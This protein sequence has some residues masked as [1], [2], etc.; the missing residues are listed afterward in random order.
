[1]DEPKKSKSKDKIVKSEH[2]S[3]K[4]DDAHD[5]EDHEEKKVETDQDVNKEESADA[6]KHE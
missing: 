2:K 4:A 5:H 6:E 1:M 3:E